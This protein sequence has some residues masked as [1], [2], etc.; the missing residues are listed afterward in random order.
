M[1]LKVSK[2]GILCMALYITNV[3][4]TVAGGHGIG[5]NFAEITIVPELILLEALLF[6]D[7]KANVTLLEVPWYLVVL[8]VLEPILI[9]GSIMVLFGC[10]GVF[11]NIA[12]MHFDGTGQMLLTLL[13]DLV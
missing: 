7:F 10:I 6:G 8:V 3:V 9:D 5:Q 4:V 1:L 11:A 13:Q 12:E 2:Y